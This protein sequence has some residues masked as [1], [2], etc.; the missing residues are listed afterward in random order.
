[1]K[2]SMGYRKEFISLLHLALKWCTQTHD[3]VCKMID[4]CFAI[5][6]RSWTQYGTSG[7]HEHADADLLVVSRCKCNVMDGNSVKIFNSKAATNPGGLIDN[8]GTNEANQIW[9]N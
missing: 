1:M 2:R 9:K 6:G 4:Y 5:I 3:F 8:N 7:L